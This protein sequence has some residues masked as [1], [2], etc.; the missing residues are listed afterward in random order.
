[1]WGDKGDTKMT[2]EE[3]RILLSQ[4]RMFEDVKIR[5]GVSPSYLLNVIEFL[6]GECDKLESIIKDGAK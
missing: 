1:M 4:G 2:I 5:I 3:A 6:L